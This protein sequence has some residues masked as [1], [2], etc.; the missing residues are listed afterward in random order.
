MEN[1]EIA[2]GPKRKK[3]MCDLSPLRASEQKFA[4][5]VLV[6]QGAVIQCVIEG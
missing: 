3:I 1:V 6:A 4:D 2:Y 5:A